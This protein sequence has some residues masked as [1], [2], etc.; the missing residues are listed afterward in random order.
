MKTIVRNKVSSAS[1]KQM[2][3][4]LQIIKLCLGYSQPPVEVSIQV[5][6]NETEIIGW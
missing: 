4:V 5:W 2:R 3:W 6:Q 1:C